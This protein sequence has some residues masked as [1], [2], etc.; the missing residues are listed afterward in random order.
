MSEII[1][2]LLWDVL[3]FFMVFVFNL[4]KIKNLAQ[5]KIYNN[6]FKIKEFLCQDIQSGQRPKERK[7][8]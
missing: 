6:I 2:V 5:D 7:P 1:D 3:L 4:S 8:L